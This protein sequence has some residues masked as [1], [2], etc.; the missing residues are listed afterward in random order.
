MRILHAPH[1]PRARAAPAQA[2][3]VGLAQAV[4]LWRVRLAACHTPTT[5]RAGVI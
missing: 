2:A 4:E 3:K 1:T 5:C